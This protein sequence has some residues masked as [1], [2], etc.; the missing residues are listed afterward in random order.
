MTSIEKSTITVG[1]AAIITVSVCSFVI[2]VMGVYYAAL[3]GVREGFDRVDKRIDNI[4]NKYNERF[5]KIE[6]SVHHASSKVMDL[7]RTVNTAINTYISEGT[8]PD[9]IRRKNYN[10]RRN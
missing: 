10:T 3:N 5:Q 7:D 6:I 1:K 8:K 2:M 9:E 4:E